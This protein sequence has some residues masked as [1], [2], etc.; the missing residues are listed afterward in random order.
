L[1]SR[2]RPGRVYRH[3]ETFLSLAQLGSVYPDYR[4]TVDFGGPFINASH[5]ALGSAPL[6]GV[7]V[8]LEARPGSG[9]IIPG[10]LRRAD[11][12]KLYELGYF[13]IGDVLELGTY[14]GLSTTIL[15]RANHDGP[16]RKRLVTVDRDPSLT[17]AA[18]G[19][20]GDAGLAE[21]VELVTG[22]AT[23]VVSRLAREGRRFDFVFVDHSHEERPVR[24]VCEQLHDVTLAGAF[25]LFHDY[26]D[27]RN[28]DPND[29]DYGVYQG[30]VEG[31]EESKFEF[32]G[33]YGCAGL[34][35]RRAN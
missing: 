34:Y 26:N 31:L 1:N 13:A 19:T 24:D 17:M 5:A 18:A 14:H 4:P 20:L 3:S 35:R 16:S 23:A 8:R 6:D 10:W 12:L 21:G 7:L 11:A 2:Y 9:K 27:L 30:V 22:D 33:I 28:A 15:S 25:C 32:F 29:G